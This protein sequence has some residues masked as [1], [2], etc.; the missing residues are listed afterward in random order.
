MEEKYIAFFNILTLTNI[1]GYQK[2]HWTYTNIFTYDNINEYISN[3]IDLG[4]INCLDIKDWY[5]TYNV[6]YV[7]ATALAL[8]KHEKTEDNEYYIM[9][10]KRELIIQQRNN[11]ETKKIIRQDDSTTILYIHK[12][13][14]KKDGRNIVLNNVNIRDNYAASRCMVVGL[15]YY[16]K[17]DIEKMINFSYLTTVVSHNTVFS[18][19]NAITLSFFTSL[20]VRKVNIIKWPYLLVELLES[21]HVKKYVSDDNDIFSDYLLVLNIWKNYIDKKF[22]KSRN[23]KEL[24]SFS[25]LIF[26]MK[27]YFDNFIYEYD[28]SYNMNTQLKKTYIVQLIICYDS[29]LDCNK[30]YEKLLFYSLF[31][32]IDST[33]KSLM[34]TIAGGLY[35]IVYGFGDVPSKLLEQ[36][37]KKKIFDKLGKECFNS[38]Y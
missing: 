6:E 29:L 8:L 37:E 36:I 19:L 9:L 15:K 28:K 30:S 7:I 24:K 20:A 34:G 13:T 2:G 16:K 5:F 23:K 14:E 26:R 1:I 38:F 27:F 18:V 3:F 17:K 11:V 4:G 12:F 10:L 32:Y 22:D 35:G 33:Y 21:S 25:N 31:V